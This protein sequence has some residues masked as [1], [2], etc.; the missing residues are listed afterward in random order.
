MPRI[1]FYILAESNIPHRFVCN[2]ASKV[3]AEGLRIHVQAESREQAVKLDDGFWTF[4]DISFI[5]HAL[6]DQ[7]DSPPCTR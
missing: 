1:D 4:R 6:A 3:R 5:P 7:A 2:L